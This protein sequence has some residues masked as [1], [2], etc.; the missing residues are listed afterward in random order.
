MWYTKTHIRLPTPKRANAL[1]LRMDSPEAARAMGTRYRHW[2][3]IAPNWFA[4]AGITRPYVRFVVG[5]PLKAYNSMLAMHALGDY[6]GVIVRQAQSIN[7]ARASIRGI[8]GPCKVIFDS[9]GSCLISTIAKA[10]RGS[11]DYLGAVTFSD[12]G[13]LVYSALGFEASSV[14]FF[15]QNFDQ[16]LGLFDAPIITGK[17]DY[18]KTIPP[19]VSVIDLFDEKRHYKSDDQLIG[20][21]ISRISGDLRIKMVMLL[22]VSRTGR[23]LPAREMAEEAKRV[24]PDAGIFVDGCQAIGRVSYRSIR[25]AFKAADGYVFVGHKALGSMISAAAAIKEGFEKSFFPTIE[26]GLMHYFKLF[27]F[28]NS[29]LNSLILEESARRGK[30]PYMVSAPEILSLSVAL[31]EN[32][33]NYPRYREISRIAK[34][35]ISAYLGRFNRLRV[36]NHP[37]TTKDIVPIATDPQGLA[38]DI[39]RYLQSASPPVTVAPLTE[40]NFIRIAIDPKLENLPRA[41]AHLKDELARGYKA[42]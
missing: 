18:K 40:N 5:A 33:A 34:E 10:M 3:D 37:R 9:N 27:Q 19:N 39:K 35:D 26:K 13:R 1:G 17:V 21:L 8:F 20:E 30:P 36:V 14:T 4:N 23:I 15:R 31:E 28:E 11:Q 7:S 24:R 32:H 2:K 16:P 22:H 42:T 41:I 25:E 29:D 38:A 6:E 12:Q